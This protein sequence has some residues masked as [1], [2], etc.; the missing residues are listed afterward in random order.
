[1]TGLTLATP[2]TGEHFAFRTSALGPAGAFQFR[3]TLD[4]GKTG[5][6][7]HQTRSGA[8]SPASS[9]GWP[10]PSRACTRCPRAG[11]VAAFERFACVDGQ[12]TT[13]LSPTGA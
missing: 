2:S 13:T 6:G 10:A 4:A 7:R 1:M 11:M 8:R 12:P 9:P 3:W 5:P